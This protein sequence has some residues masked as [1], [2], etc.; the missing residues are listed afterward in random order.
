MSN[1]LLTPTIIAKEFLRQLT[2]NLIM[3]KK[4]ART[5]ENQIVNQ[6]IGGVI[7]VK[8]PILLHRSRTAPRSSARTTWKVRSPST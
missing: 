8:R 2:N 5:F 4:V 3:G 6:K 1:T 7:T